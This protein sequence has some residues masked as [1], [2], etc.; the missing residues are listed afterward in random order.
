MNI[1]KKYNTVVI[2][3]LVIFFSAL[4][5]IFSCYETRINEYKKSAYEEII[6]F[7]KGVKADLVG[8][9]V[10]VNISKYP[11]PIGEKL[12]YGIYSAGFK[13]GNVGITYLGQ[14]EISGVSADVVILESRAP[15]FSDVEI[16]YGDISSFTPLRVERKIYLLGENINILEEYDVKKNEVTITRKARK[17]TIEKIKCKGKISNIILL[18]YYFR[19]KNNSYKIGD[20]I[21]FS[22]PTEQLK[23]LVEKET[24]IK[25]PKGQ[26]KAIFI[27]SIPPRFKVWF[28]KDKD[29]IPL[30]IQGA[31]GVGNTYLALLD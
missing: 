9:E 31:I 14:K 3:I 20:E 17:T 27:K 29:S 21:E 5:F 19:Y 13:V 18:L 15:G 22:L 23:M 2:L 24:E 25:V 28:L 12:R 10:K 8:K 7:A 6:G 11:F 1:H 4:F 30:R 26:F 16:I